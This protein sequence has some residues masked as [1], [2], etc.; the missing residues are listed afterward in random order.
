MV[1]NN[2]LARR[3]GGVAMHVKLLPLLNEKVS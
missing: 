1:E 3:V 2:M